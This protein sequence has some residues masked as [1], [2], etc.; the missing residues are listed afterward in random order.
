MGEVLCCMGNHKKMAGNLVWRVFLLVSVTFVH[1]AAEKCD[2]IKL[3]LWRRGGIRWS[4]DHEGF[5]PK[6]VPPGGIHRRTL[7][8]T[9]SCY[10]GSQ[11]IKFQACVWDSDKEDYP[12][13]EDADCGEVYTCCSKELGFRKFDAVGHTGRKWQ[14]V[15]NDCMKKA[16]E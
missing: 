16:K 8:N 7:C 10:A 3:K 4:V 12:R 6:D 14:K 11:K 1:V 9:I 5:T 15:Y 13:S 2:N